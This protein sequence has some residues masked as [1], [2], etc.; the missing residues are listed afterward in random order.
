MLLW[1]WKILQILSHC[2]IFGLPRWLSGEESTCQCK[3]HRRHGFDH[4]IK[5]ISWRRKWQLALIFLPGEF[6]EQR[7]WWRAT[8][9]G[10]TESGPTENSAGTHSIIFQLIMN[11]CQDVILWK[12]IGYIFILSLACDFLKRILFI[13]QKTCNST[14]MYVLTLKGKDL[15]KGLLNTYAWNQPAN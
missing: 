11:D 14:N 9:H 15:R 7:T 13:K 6:H 10:V 2:I 4:W 8:A 5:K 3:S 1:I 12:S